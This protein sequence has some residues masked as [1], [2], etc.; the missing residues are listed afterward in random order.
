V[1]AELPDLVVG[2]LPD[3]LVPPGRAG[4]PWKI[5]IC[6]TAVELDAVQAA[7]A[8]PVVMRDGGLDFRASVDVHAAT[9]SRAEPPIAGVYAPGLE[10]WPWIALFR[11]PEAAGAAVQAQRGRY[12]WELFDSKEGAHGYVASVV[13][14]VGL[15]GV[16]RVV[17]Q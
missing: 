1:V 5:W 13:D 2:R 3:A 17:V 16:V 9:P 14:R 8:R 10:G 15:T 6:E 4:G 11:W 12:T 7:L